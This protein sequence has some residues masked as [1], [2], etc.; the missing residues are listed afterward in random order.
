MLLQ[1]IAGK[2]TAVFAS[3]DAVKNGFNAVVY[4]QEKV[5]AVPA[6]EMEEIAVKFV[7]MLLLP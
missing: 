2:S 3:A 6:G 7:P 1:Y 4:T 5:W